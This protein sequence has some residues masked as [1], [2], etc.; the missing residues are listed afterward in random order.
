MTAHV[1]RKYFNH[2]KAIRALRDTDASFNE[3]CNDYEEM[4]TWLAAQNCLTDSLS[5]ECTHAREIIRDLE[6][7]IKTAQMEAGYQIGT[8]EQVANK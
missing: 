1:C 7:E 5:E 3:M 8:Q 6:A 2:T 4:C